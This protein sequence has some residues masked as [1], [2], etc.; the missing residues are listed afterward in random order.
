MREVV[1]KA[2]VGV[3][4]VL[5]KVAKEMQSGNKLTP[6]EMQTRF[7]LLHEGNP[8]AIAQFASRFAPPGVNP[9]VAAHEYEQAMMNGKQQ[10]GTQ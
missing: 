5:A 3:D 2:L 7:K 6:D 1:H 4:E 9:L 10:G 8:W